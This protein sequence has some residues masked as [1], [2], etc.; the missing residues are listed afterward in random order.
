[1]RSA[2]FLRYSSATRGARTAIVSV[3]VSMTDMRE[4]RSALFKLCEAVMEL[5]VPLVVAQIMDIGIAGGAM[6]QLLK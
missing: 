5:L 2:S 1:M 3:S 4:S 6:H